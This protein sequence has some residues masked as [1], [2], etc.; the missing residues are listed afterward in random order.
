M[1]I[2]YTY[3]II[4]ICIVSFVVYVAHLNRLYIF[5]CIYIYPFDLFLFFELQCL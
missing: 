2:L 5:V 1:T 4:W 3:G